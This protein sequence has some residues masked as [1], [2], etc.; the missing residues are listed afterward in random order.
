M[1]QVRIF[2]YMNKNHDLNI[3]FPLSGGEEPDFKY[4]NISLIIIGA[5][6]AF[7]LI[8][9]FVFHWR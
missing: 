6:I 1:V 8:A 4:G 9:H 2:I 3:D 5:I 7:G